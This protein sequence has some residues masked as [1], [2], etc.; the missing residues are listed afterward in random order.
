ML[1]NSTAPS[2]AK[3]LI[4]KLYNLIRD[5]NLHFH[6]AYIPTELNVISDL[7]SRGGAICAPPIITVC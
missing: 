2:E 5:Y 4:V 7:L 1:R 3:V 6:Y